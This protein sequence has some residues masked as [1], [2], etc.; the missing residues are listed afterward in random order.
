[1]QLAACVIVV[2]RAAASVCC[3]CRLPDL[4]DRRPIPSLDEFYCCMSYDGRRRIEMT[5]CL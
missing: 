4:S 1:M 3:A 2:D 5:L